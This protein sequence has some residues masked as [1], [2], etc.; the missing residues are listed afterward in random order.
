MNIVS[1]IGGLLLLVGGGELLVRGAAGLA[2]KAKIPSIIVG[3]TVV[4]IGTSSPELFASLNAAASGADGIAIGNVVGSNM[5]N[6]GLVLAITALVFP[7]PVEKNLLKLDWPVMMVASLLFLLFMQDLELVW[8]EGLIFVL[9]LIFYIFRLIYIT[10]RNNKM[11]AELTSDE[12]EFEEFQSKPYW[13]LIVLVVVG[14]TL[15]YFGAEWFIE[16]ASNI[17]MSLGISDTVIGL[18][19]VAFGTSVPELVTSLMAAFK[20]ETDIGL[21]NL[22]GSNIFNILAVLGITSLVS[23]L[24]MKPE[25]LEPNFIHNQ[26]WWMFAISFVIMPF[27]LIGKNKIGRV[28]GLI[29]LAAYITYIFLVLT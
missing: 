16:G 10:R 21:G 5:A 9:A 14:C 12:K 15:L 13:V 11:Q 19:V 1:L 27:V 25:P 29:L 17:A 8:W 24:D 4:S 26:I 7:I 20:K 18:T 6:L 3:L 2:L 22:V 28:K 23:P